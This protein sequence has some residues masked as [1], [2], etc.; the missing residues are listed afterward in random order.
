MADPVFI[1]IDPS[2]VGTGVCVLH[3]GE[4]TPRYATTV[5]TKNLMGIER[6]IKIR[7]TVLTILTNTSLKS[8]IV[9]VCIEGYGFGCKGN[10][11]FN[12][13]ELGGIL[14]V[15][16]YEEG[17]GYIDVPPTSLKKFITG[18]GTSK[19]EVMLERVFRRWGIGSEVLHDNNQVDAFS[20][21]KFG[22]A[23]HRW[24]IGEAAG[25]QTEVQAFS[26]VTENIRKIAVEKS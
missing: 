13:G 22:E 1:G 6:L 11:I 7:D 12:L 16:L 17:Y 10:A 20:L 8:N 3:F 15:M 19:K 9:N 18:K 5:L 14:R 25:T 4:S 2:L 21:A 24:R 26:K 23:Y